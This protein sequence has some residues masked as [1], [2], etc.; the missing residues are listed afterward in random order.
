MRKM[1][2]PPTP[3]IQEKADNH[4]AEVLRADYRLLPS[5]F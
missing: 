3:T 5:N 2:N 1:F 4:D